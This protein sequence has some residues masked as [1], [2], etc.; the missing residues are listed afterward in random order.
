M[1]SYLARK[2]GVSPQAVRQTALGISSSKRIR[3]AVLR[4]VRR[5]KSEI[6][7]VAA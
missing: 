4:E 1:Y 7:E 2:L 6:E 3:E 5:R